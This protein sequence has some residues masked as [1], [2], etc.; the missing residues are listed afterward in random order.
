MAD[1]DQAALS[2]FQS[3]GVDPE[4]AL[5]RIRYEG[6]VDRATAA[7]WRSDEVDEAARSSGVS[8][9]DAMMAVERAHE[10]AYAAYA[11]AAKRLRQSAPADVSGDTAA[12]RAIRNEQ[13]DRVEK[14]AA[15]EETANRN[16]KMKR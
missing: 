13:L 5:H 7:Q 16:R 9:A 15:A 11:H 8:G 1:A 2:A 4:T 12:A 10:A 14:A 3:A 6:P